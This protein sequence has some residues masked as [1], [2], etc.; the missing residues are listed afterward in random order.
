MTPEAKLTR[1]AKLE[2]DVYE[3]ST[4]RLRQRIDQLEASNKALTD[5]MRWRFGPSVALPRNQ[6]EG[7]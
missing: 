6:T 4:A 1:L 7:A 3:N 2:S 5:A